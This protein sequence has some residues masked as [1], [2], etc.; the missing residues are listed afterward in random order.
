M[1]LW[2][3]KE[4]HAMTAKTPVPM[5]DPSSQEDPLTA[6]FSLWGLRL[7]VCC[8]LLI[9]IYGVTNYLLNWLVR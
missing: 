6:K 9:V 5:L 2:N 1:Y 8:A 7:W 4:P 3:G